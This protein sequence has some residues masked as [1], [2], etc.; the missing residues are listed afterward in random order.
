MEHMTGNIAVAWNWFC[1][2]YGGSRKLGL[3]LRQR[4]GW[5]RH[6]ANRKGQ[7]KGIVAT[8]NWYTGDLLSFWWQKLFQ[9]VHVVEAATAVPFLVICLILLFIYFFLLYLNFWTS[10]RAVVLEP[11][12][13][14]WPVVNSSVTGG[15]CGCGCDSSDALR[16]WI[17]VLS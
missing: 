12:M 1:Y 7:W 10:E 13:D 15:C 9:K 8:S 14:I 17:C 6:F 16:M 5:Y 2:L 4:C 11:S 3:V